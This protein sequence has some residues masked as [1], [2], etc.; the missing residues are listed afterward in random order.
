MFQ[1]RWTPWLDNVRVYIAG[2]LNVDQELLGPREIAEYLEQTPDKELL[3]LRG[4][5][6]VRLARLRERLRNV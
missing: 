2:Q 6:K 4:L 1:N 3:R 5:G